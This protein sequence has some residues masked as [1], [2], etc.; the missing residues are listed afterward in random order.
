[1]KSFMGNQKQNHK[2]LRN[3]SSALLADNLRFGSLCIVVSLTIFKTRL[4]GRGFHTLIRNVSFPSPTKVGS[5]NPPLGDPSSLLA[6][7]PVFVFDTISNGSSSLRA[8]TVHFGRLR[9]V[10]SL[11]VFKT[12]LLGRDFHTLIRNVLFS[13][14]T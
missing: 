4:L 10:V 5:H 9:I 11:T 3:S 1:M 7:R 12:R 14:P 8:D 6:H 2:G 13:S